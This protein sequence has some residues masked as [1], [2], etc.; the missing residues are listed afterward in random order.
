[1]NTWEILFNNALKQIDTAK[2][3]PDST[4]FINDLARAN[5]ITLNKTMKHEITM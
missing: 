3:P 5:G 2:L 1:M 4:Q